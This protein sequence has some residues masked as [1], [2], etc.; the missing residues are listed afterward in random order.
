MFYLLP[1]LLATS[2]LFFPDFAFAWGPIAHLHFA[3]SLMNLYRELPSVV[4]SILTA[5]PMDF[6]YGCIAADI[7]IGKRFIEYMHNCHSWDV[8]LEILNQAGDAP[9]QAFAYGYLCHL[10]ADTVSHNYF[11]PYH[12]VSSYKTRLLKHIYWEMRFD[13]VLHR[14][15]L[16]RKAHELAQKGRYQHH[17]DFLDRILKRTLFSFKTN[18]R[19]FS[20]LILLHNIDHWQ[21]ATSHMHESS[22]WHLNRDQAREYE[23]LAIQFI[24]DFFKNGKKSHSYTK[25][26]SGYLTLAEAQRKRLELK[27]KARSHT[28]RDEDLQNEI[29]RFKSKLRKK[30]LSV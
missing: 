5:H 6:Y 10:G 29:E 13:V 27:E 30:L 23:E 11:V 7:T 20:G 1:L 14:P 16:T 26:P 19:I 25:D 21:R 3:Q 4:S 15:E 12:L 8:G 28:M 17:D 18:R 9:T 22:K 2:V 24:S